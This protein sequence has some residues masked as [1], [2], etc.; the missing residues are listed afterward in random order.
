MKIFLQNHFMKVVKKE[1]KKKKM[2]IKKIMQAILTKLKQIILIM[3]IQI[4]VKVILII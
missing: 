1:G 4:N 3:K 2:K